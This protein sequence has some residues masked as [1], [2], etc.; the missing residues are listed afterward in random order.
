MEK[1]I[2]IFSDHAKAA[3]ADAEADAALT[4]QQRLEI[5][6]ELQRRQY[7]NAAEQRLARVCRVV[8]LEDLE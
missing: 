1:R 2:R 8:K 7:P 4:P 5:L 3:Q 6:F